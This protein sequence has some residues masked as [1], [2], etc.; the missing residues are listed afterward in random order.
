MHHVLPNIPYNCQYKTFL[1]GERLPSGIV[2][3]YPVCILTWQ[4][5]LPMLSHE[6]VNE[7][8]V[9]LLLLAP[10]GQREVIP[11][12]N[13]GLNANFLI[14]NLL[15][16]ED[17]VGILETEHWS[18]IRLHDMSS[19]KLMNY[20]GVLPILSNELA[21]FVH[22]EYRNLGLPCLLLDKD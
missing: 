9:Q 3:R 14:K 13:S 21:S 7:Y 20:Y 19:R 10:L 2:I 11:A 5:I 6:L 4:L 17:E 8:A 12:G 18:H 15:S 1:L 16:Q 22:I